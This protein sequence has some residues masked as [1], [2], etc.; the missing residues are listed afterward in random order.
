MIFFALSH[1]NPVFFSIDKNT[2]I[3]PLRIK[4]QNLKV[5][6]YTTVHFLLLKGTVSVILSD[7][8]Y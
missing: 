2:G 4:I 5:T 8:S 3:N 7:P 6:S 1:I